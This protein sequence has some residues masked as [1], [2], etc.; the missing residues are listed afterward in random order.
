MGNIN[1]Q[2]WKN[3]EKGPS[4]PRLKIPKEN[5]GSLFWDDYFE[6]YFIGYNRNH[7]EG[8]VNIATNEFPHS[9][10]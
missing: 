4:M 8:W 2:L 10:C 7:E 9:G 3:L 6:F 5:D 1:G